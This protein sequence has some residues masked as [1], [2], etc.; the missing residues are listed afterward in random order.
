MTDHRCALGNDQAL[1]GG[2]VNAQVPLDLEQLVMDELLA[3]LPNVCLDLLQR[4]P[5]RP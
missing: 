3:E 4:Q 1:N 5:G 2:T